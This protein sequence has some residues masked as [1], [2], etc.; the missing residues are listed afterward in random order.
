MNELIKFEFQGKD[1]FAIDVDGKPYFIAADICEILSL[2][3]VSK[4]LTSLDNDEKLTLPVVRAGQ[5][6]EVNMVSE[7][8]LY[9]LVFKSK[10]PEAKAFKKLV[11]S[12]VLP[13]IRKTGTYVSKQMSIEEMIIMQA[14]SVLDVKKDIGLL[15][16]KV[17]ELEAKSITSP[18][19]YFTIAGYAS[20]IGKKVDVPTA[21]QIGRKAT[22]LCG[23]L[24]YLTGTIPDPRFGKVKTYPTEVLKTAFDQYYV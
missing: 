6:R 3:N 4:A 18:N 5:T 19:D 10:K 13:S 11:T 8:G 23:T 12:V 16:D 21:A 20:L 22:N 2:S 15:G 24:G 14:Q 9:S 17:K 1:F 7:S